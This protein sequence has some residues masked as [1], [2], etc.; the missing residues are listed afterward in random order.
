MGSLYNEWAPDIGFYAY[1]HIY[2]YIYMYMFL[3]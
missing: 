2:M 1:L 3:E